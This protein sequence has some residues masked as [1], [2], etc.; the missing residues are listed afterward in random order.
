MQKRSGL[1]NITTLSRHYK[2]L[3]MS[4]TNIGRI[5]MCVRV[6]GL[7]GLYMKRI[8]GVKILQKHIIF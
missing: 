2:Q 7:Y 4:K 1:Y 3:N 5:I 8:S 6:G